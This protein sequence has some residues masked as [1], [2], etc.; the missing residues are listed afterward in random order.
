MV[1][2]TKVRVIWC[3]GYDL[4]QDMMF[5]AEHIP[6]PYVQLREIPSAVLS[7][8]NRLNKLI[9]HLIRNGLELQNVSRCGFGQ[10]LPHRA[11]KVS[12]NK[13]VLNEVCFLNSSLCLRRWGWGS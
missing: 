4:V 5:H 8:A 1:E 10:R 13:E 9:P 6:L 11:Q 2:C 12:V 7:G 3:L